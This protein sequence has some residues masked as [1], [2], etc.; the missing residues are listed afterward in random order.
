[1]I[2]L[3]RGRSGFS[4]KT[5]RWTE[6]TLYKTKTGKFICEQIDHTQWQGDTDVHGGEVCEN[7]DEVIEFFGNGLLANLILPYIPSWAFKSY[8]ECQVFCFIFA[9]YRKGAREKM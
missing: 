5:G 3:F 4:G 7:V 2:L 8:R 1:M 6:L 9:S